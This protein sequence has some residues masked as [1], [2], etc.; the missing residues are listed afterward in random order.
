MSAHHY[1][2]VSTQRRYDGPVI[3]LRSDTVRMPG[4]VTA[5]RD[6]VEHPGAVGV[7][8]LDDDERVLMIRQYRHPVGDYLWELPAG[9][10]DTPG[11]PPA[12]TARRELAEEAG[13]TARD[14][15]VL[16]DCYSSSGMSD[17]AFRVYLARQISAKADDFVPGEHEE[18]DL[19]EEWVPL[20]VAVARV[21]AGEITNALAAVG[22]LACAGARVASYAGLRPADAPWPARAR[23][24][25]VTEPS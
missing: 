21:L 22:I 23:S 12:Q 19:V 5:V 10:L 1:E 8:A 9:L 24:R 13:V 15:W 6:V 20:D 4:G 25:R 16:V 18:A 2:V 17:E 14:W 7:V 11:E 3:S